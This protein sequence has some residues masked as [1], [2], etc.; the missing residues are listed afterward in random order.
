MKKY[1]VWQAGWGDVPSEV[2]EIEV[3]DDKCPACSAFSPHPNPSVVNELVVCFQLLEPNS[4]IERRYLSESKLITTFTGVK[5]WVCR[6]ATEGEL[7]DAEEEAEH[8]RAGKLE[9]VDPPTEEE[10]AK[11]RATNKR[12]GEI[13]IDTLELIFNP[14]AWAAR[15]GAEIGEQLAKKKAEK[16]QHPR[17]PNGPSGPSA[18]TAPDDKTWSDKEKP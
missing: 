3:E 10:K 11:Q 13:V 9:E 5:G 1:R 16:Q 15:R 14:T 12:F 17:K 4:P 8:I 7:R 2:H 6:V 18:K